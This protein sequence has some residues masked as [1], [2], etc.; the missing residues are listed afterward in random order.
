MISIQEF[1]S[2]FSYSYVRYALAVGVL[3][4]LCASLLGVVLVLKRFSY[5]GDGLSHVA[6]G[7][8][9]LAVV[10]NLANDLAL[11]MPVT[12]VCAVLLLGVGEGKKINGDAALAMLSVGSLAIGYVLLNLFPASSNIAGDVCSS[13]FGS[14]SILTLGAD[15]VILCIVMSIVVI[16]VFVLLYNK[17]FALTFDPVF[18]QASGG[19]ARW[20]NLLIAVL[21]AVVISLSMRLVGSLLVSALIIF[22]AISAMSVQRSFRAVIVTS[23]VIGVVCA[24]LGMLL[25]MIFSTP[26]GASIVLCDIIAFAVCKGISKIKGNG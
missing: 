18:M 21:C 23:A 12:V 14:S 3:V 5:L 2:Y 22:P 11:V 24:A 16:G 10:L 1:L 8:M 25:S 26:T 9:A 4:A 13:L 20:Y 19:R 15:D 7:A 17:I 6:F